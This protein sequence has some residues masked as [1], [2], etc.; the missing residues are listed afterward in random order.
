MEI[1]VLFFIAAI[2]AGV[3]NSLAGGG[4][5]FAHIIAAGS[6]PPA[7]HRPAPQLC[8]CLVARC[9]SGHFR[10]SGIWRLLWAGI[11]ILMVSALSFM[12][13]NEIRQVLALKKL[14]AGSLR[15]VAVAVL[16]ADSLVNWRYGLPMALGGL[17]GG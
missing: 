3:I 13:L 10:S 1:H 14:L 2:V 12:G 17:M 15:G 16:L 6:G 4:G 7:T 5:H 11:G 8:V 9:R